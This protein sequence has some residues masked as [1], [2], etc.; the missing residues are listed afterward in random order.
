MNH[1]DHHFI[2]SLLNLKLKRFFTVIL[3]ALETLAW[4]LYMQKVEGVVLFATHLS[5]EFKGPTPPMP[6]TPKK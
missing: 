1:S 3:L 4:T 2:G 5:W 6:H